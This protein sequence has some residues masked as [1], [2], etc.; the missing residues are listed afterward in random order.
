[1]LNNVMKHAICQ[2][3]STNF[4]ITPGSFGKFCS[5]SCGVIFRS[6]INL[7][8][9]IKKYQF[10]P[11]KCNCCQKPLDYTKRKNKYCSRSCSAKIHAWNQKHTERVTGIEPAT[12]SLEG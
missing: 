1:M 8:N 3:C 11:A 6:K 4:I 12:N 2:Q 9:A 5:L 10:T 7:K